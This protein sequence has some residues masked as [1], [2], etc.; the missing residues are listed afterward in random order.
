MKGDGDDPRALIREA[1]RIEGITEADCRVIFLD[2]AMGQPEETPAEPA[3]RR[4]LDRYGPAEPDH[5][6]TRVLEESFG[7]AETPRRRGG[8]RARLGR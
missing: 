4:L 6:M 3:I 7:E 2:W 5:P 8:R 1:Y